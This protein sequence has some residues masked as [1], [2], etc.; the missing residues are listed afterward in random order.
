[1]GNKSLIIKNLSYKL[2][3]ILLVLFY[4]IGLSSGD[5]K[6][7]DE[8]YWL[9]LTSFQGKVCSF[10]S[11]PSFFSRFIQTINPY[12][13]E[14]HPFL[15]RS[16]SLMPGLLTLFL[17]YQWSLSWMEKE[18]SFWTSCILG[19]SL[20]YFYE[21]RLFGPQ[22]WEIFFLTLGLGGALKSWFSQK[23][24][25]KTWFLLYPLALGGL[26]LFHSERGLWTFLIVSC[27]WSLGGGIQ[28]FFPGKP[29][30]KDKNPK[31]SF[32]SFFLISAFLILC[33]LFFLKVLG[34][35]EGRPESL[36]LPS[37][38][39]QS[40]LSS[41]LFLLFSFMPW[42]MFLPSVWKETFSLKG[43][44]L[45][46][47]EKPFL[48]LWILGAWICSF[49]ETP[50]VYRPF[51]SSFL[52]CLPPL[53][54][55]VGPIV[56]K[57]WK[58]GGKGGLPL[59]ISSS[60]YFFLVSLFSI[61]AFSQ[62]L[63]DPDLLNVWYPL[64]LLI[65]FAMIGAMVVLYAAFFQ[66]ARFALSTIVLSHLILMHLMDVASPFLMGNHKGEIFAETIL[67][68]LKP[69]D[70]IVLYRHVL[71]DLPIRTER[72][73]HTCESPF[74]FPAHEEISPEILK[75]IWNEKGHVYLLIS[76]NHLDD[77]LDHTQETNPYFLKKEGHLLLM[78][79]HR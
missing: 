25:D 29:Q 15:L 54:W 28:A 2:I 48:W 4:F 21:T 33:P 76:E 42:T 6:G 70:S 11:C 43:K 44:A 9:N 45:E 34:Q 1:M 26:W 12:P 27:L 8:F 77:F 57:I 68:T 63:H 22:G 46:N 51:L 62:G 74:L 16:L 35:G 59:K 14:T 40:F 60:F 73:I 52:F 10:F 66:K 53:A 17:A 5:F 56:F 3:F 38:H 39:F 30:I 78:R 79:N 71:P 37:F 18:E 64:L 75:K 50:Q 13:L 31:K 69:E 58:E 72:T 7:L 67:S 32:L 61:L 19:T 36:V 41:L 49:L 24:K 23:M 20:L 55:M 65:V 47:S